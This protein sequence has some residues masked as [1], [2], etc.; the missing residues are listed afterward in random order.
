MAY[1]YGIGTSS[2]VRG[3]PVRQRPFAASP[4]S[5]QEESTRAGTGYWELSRGGGLLS[6]RKTY[7][8][9]VVHTRRCGGGGDRRR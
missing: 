4:W 2:P 3:S 6:P 9:E 7:D 5:D 1:G 8:A